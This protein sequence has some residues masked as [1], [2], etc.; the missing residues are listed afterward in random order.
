MANRP[1]AR[2]SRIQTE[3]N[4]I[5]CHELQARGKC[6]KED[7]SNCEQMGNARKKA[8]PIMS[9]SDLLEGRCAQSSA[10]GNCSKEK[11]TNREQ[12]RNV[13]KRVRPITSKREMLAR[14][15]VQLRAKRKY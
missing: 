12:K 5:G 6:S 3:K 11:A 1:P 10:K 2:R 7:A 8:R 9:K 14:G 15:R 13:G 4:A